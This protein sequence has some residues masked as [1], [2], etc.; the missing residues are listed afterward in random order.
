MNQVPCGNIFNPPYYVNSGWFHR[1]SASQ[2]TLTV[3]TDGNGTING[4]AEDVYGFIECVQIGIDATNPSALKVDNRIYNA[5]PNDGYRFKY[6]QCGQGFGDGVDGE[7]IPLDKS[8]MF[9]KENYSEP[10]KIKAVFEPDD[11]VAKA[12][13]VKKLDG[14]K[15]VDAA[16]ALLTLQFSISKVTLTEAQ[17][18]AADVDLNKVVDAADSLLI[19]QKSIG[20]IKELPIKK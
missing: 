15:V 18:V 19:L 7:V 2:N 5:Q 10:M 17:K 6:W 8:G 16:D 3:T 11:A 1:A 4:S 20:K 9:T 13:L 12:S 14:D